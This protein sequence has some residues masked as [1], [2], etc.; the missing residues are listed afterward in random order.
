M[1]A[2]L[3]S[4]EGAARLV[5]RH[6]LAT[7]GVMGPTVA[8]LTG[9]DADDDATSVMLGTIPAGMVVPMHSHGDPETFIA[10][11]G[12][13]DGLSEKA[14]DFRWLPIG[15]GAV[16]HVPGGAK[17]AF[18]NPY[19]EPSVALIVSTVRIA[20]FFREIGT[21]AGTRLPGPPDDATLR[22]FRDASE[23]VGYWNAT[24]EENARVG[25]SLP[26]S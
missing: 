2:L 20:R 3:E 24:P 26:G 23:R 1:L 6:D 7:V 8:F 10:I 4:I 13:L 18:R 21:P 5:S 19:A 17:H 16:F 15:P 9:I 22:R 25:L 11:S 12:R 14:G